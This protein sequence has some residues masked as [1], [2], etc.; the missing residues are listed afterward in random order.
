MP[1]DRNL[2]RCTS[3]PH[4]LLELFD[5]R[6]GG[7]GFSDLVSLNIFVYKPLQINT[8]S[9]WLRHYV[10]MNGRIKTNGDS[11]R[12]S[13][14]WLLPFI[15]S[16]SAGPTALRIIQNNLQKCV[17]RILTWCLTQTILNEWPQAQDRDG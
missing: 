13:S 1:L 5:D 8:R 14:F 12:S 2:T 15:K 10:L 4:L 16:R 6:F 11:R 7:G 9:T 3:L 17:L